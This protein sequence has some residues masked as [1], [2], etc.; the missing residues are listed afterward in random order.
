MSAEGTWH[1]EVTRRLP[2]LRKLDGKFRTVLAVL[3][4]EETRVP[5]TVNPDVISHAHRVPA[6]LVP[7]AIRAKFGR[8][9]GTR[10]KPSKLLQSES[11]ATV[12]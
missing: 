11:L 4:Q 2:N 12:C 5:V 9:E 6:N 7:R 3:L 1:S 8:R 10:K